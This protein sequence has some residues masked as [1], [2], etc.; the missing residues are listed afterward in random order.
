M[1]NLLPRV[2]MR[3]SLSLFKMGDLLDRF[4]EWRERRF[5]NIMVCSMLVLLVDVIL[6]ILYPMFVVGTGADGAIRTPFARGLFLLGWCIFI[7]VMPLILAPKSTRD[8]WLE[9]FILVG[10]LGTLVGPFFPM[11]L[12]NSPSETPAAIVWVSGGLI[13]AGGLF[14]I[15]ACLYY[16]MQARRERYQLA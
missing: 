10:V 15:V 12:L 6:C 3:K 4:F 13:F 14:T 16:R 7:G 9:Q 11:V 8:E 2:K 5:E 1:K